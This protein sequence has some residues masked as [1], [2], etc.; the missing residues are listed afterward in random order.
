MSG[1]RNGK[2]ENLVLIDKTIGGDMGCKIKTMCH[3]IVNFPS[4]SSYF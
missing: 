1:C 2:G 4:F 3:I